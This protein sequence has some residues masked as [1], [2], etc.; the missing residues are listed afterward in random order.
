MTEGPL[1][2]PFSVFDELMVINGFVDDREALIVM[3]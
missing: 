2:F 3:T 1:I